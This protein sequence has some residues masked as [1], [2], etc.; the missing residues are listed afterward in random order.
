MSSTWK[1]RHTP[2]FPLLGVLVEAA[3]HIFFYLRC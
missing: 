2:V 1:D 3:S